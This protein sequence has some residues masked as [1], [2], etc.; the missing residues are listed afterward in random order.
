MS[1]KATK[2][3]QFMIKQD[4]DDVIQLQYGSGLPPNWQMIKLGDLVEEAVL[5]IKS[6]FPQG[7]HNEEGRGVPHLRPF[8]ITSDSDIDLSQVKNVEPVAQD[9]TYWLSLGDVIFNNT[10]SEELVGKTAYFPFKGKFVL[11]NHMT[12]MRVLDLIVVE[13]YCLSKILH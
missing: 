13:P 8:N 5:F 12:L 1:K 11:S 4:A 10:N 7:V 9:S 2:V 3:Q 6:G